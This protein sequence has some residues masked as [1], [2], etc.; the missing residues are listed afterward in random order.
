MP[1]LMTAKRLF[2]LW[3]SGQGLLSNSSG[4]KPQRCVGV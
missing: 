1:D 2:L 3:V 4:E